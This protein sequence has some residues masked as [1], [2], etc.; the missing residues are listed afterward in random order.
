MNTTKISWLILVSYF[1]W[2]GQ[3]YLDMPKVMAKRES[4]FCQEWVKLWRLF[5][6]YGKESIEVTNLFNHFKWVWSDVPNLI[7]N[8]KLEW[9]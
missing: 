2:G 4:A 7:Q 8:N 9:T 6:A 3:A 1:K 5:F